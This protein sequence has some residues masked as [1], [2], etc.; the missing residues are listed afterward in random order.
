M[1]IVVCDGSDYF[2]NAFRKELTN[3]DSTIIYETFSSY[4]DLLASEEVKS[5]DGIFLAT[6]INGKS[7]IESALEIK[8]QNPK[9]EIM[10][11]T[12]QCEKYAQKIFYYADKLRPYAF[13]IKPMSRPLMRHFLSLLEYQ[14]T[15]KDSISLKI[16]DIEG[17]YHSVESSEILYISYFDRVT[18]VHCE[19]EKIRT[20]QI[21][22][23]FDALL[24]QHN[25]FHSA[26]SCIVNAFFVE[27]YNAGE[28][29]LKNGRKI[30]ASRNYKQA[31]KDCMDDYAQKKLKLAENLSF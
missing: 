9:A 20:R 17:V 27:D 13:F 4:D 8:H 5:A 31:F 11:V 25:F 22:P 29:T 12:E 7:G 18:E 30:F 24:N 6:E 28:I 23:Q 3:Y 2:L 19:E 16:K 15:F 14:I 26:K 1:N 21:I 10:F